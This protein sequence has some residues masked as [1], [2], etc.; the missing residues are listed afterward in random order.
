[1]LTALAVA[2]GST[3]RRMVQYEV[4]KV[5]VPP[6]PA[7]LTIAGPLLPGNVTASNSSNYGID[8]HDVAYDPVNQCGG[9]NKPAVGLVA[10]QNA[11]ATTS[12]NNFINA[13]PSGRVNNYTG[14]D[15]CSPDVQNVNNTS[16]Q[17]FNTV[18]GLQGLVTSVQG[19]ATNSYGTNP[20]SPNIGCYSCNPQQY[21]VTAVSGN[22]NLSGS[23]VDGYG[24][25][26]VTGTLTL[27]GNF[28]YHGLILVVGQGQIVENG[29]GSGGITGAIVLANIGDNSGCGVAGG[30]CY[31]TNPTDQ[32]L[33]SQLGNPVYNYPGG[34]NAGFHYDS[35]MIRDITAK[36]N[37]TVIA[38][39][40]ITY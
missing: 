17:A 37:F 14:V 19:A 29:G 12:M 20:S 27:S 36:A 24:I 8:G 7:A 40:E 13:I 33:L 21:S 3:T 30:H 16:N 31:S 23:T 2:P 1:M 18:Y 32:N 34:G 4:A 6:V 15:G 35:C 5:P 10:A 26:L 39:R 38:R 9:Q 22:L 28:S 25:L 11:D